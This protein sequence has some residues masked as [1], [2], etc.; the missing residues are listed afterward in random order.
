[1]KEIMVSIYG[2]KMEFLWF[3]WSHVV[4]H[5][6]ALRVGGMNALFFSQKVKVQSDITSK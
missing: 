4:D 5:I 3:L 2:G 6:L 1:M